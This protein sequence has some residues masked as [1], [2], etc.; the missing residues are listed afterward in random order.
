V[1]RDIAVLRRL[2][3][4]GALSTSA[5]EFLSERLE[6]VNVPAGE[7]F[8]A[9]AELGDS[10]FVLEEGR[11]EVVKSR[12]GQDVVLATI[13]PGACFGE[14][15]LLAICPR[16][17]T[18]R[19]LTDCRALRLS[20]RVLFELYERDL[21]QFTLVQMNLGREVAR[22]LSALDELVC[23]IADEAGRRRLGRTLK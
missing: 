15:A 20:N 12:P 3:I 13:E 22:R 11:A 9:E 6:S 18:V 16:T 4:F 2:S 1:A 21:E 19:A 17:A 10:V 23:E 8:F 5:L 14:I 7:A